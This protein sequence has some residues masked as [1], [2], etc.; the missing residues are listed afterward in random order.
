MCLK[1]FISDQTKNIGSWISGECPFNQV[2]TSCS[3]LSCLLLCIWS[4]HL[5]LF[6]YSCSLHSVQTVT[7]QV[8]NIQYHFVVI[9][10]LLFCWRRELVLFQEL[11][12]LK[13]FE[14]TENVLAA[15]LQEKLTEKL[16]MDKMVINCSIFMHY[17]KEHWFSSCLSRYTHCLAFE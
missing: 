9:Q 5:W 17:R 2:V 7:Q 1:L 8:I 3:F 16:N 10:L 12:L 14:K 11:L 15:K 13:E 6:N 4:N